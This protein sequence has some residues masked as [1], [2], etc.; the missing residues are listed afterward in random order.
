MFCFDILLGEIGGK[1][2]REKQWIMKQ[3]PRLGAV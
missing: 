2:R 3:Y 1:G